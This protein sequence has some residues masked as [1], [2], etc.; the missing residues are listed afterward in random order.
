MPPLR[1]LARAAEGRQ[2]LLEMRHGD[3]D[4]V[5]T[6]MTVALENHFVTHFD[7]VLL[8]DLGYAARVGRTERPKRLE[9]ARSGFWP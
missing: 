9:C 8:P 1:A 4:S 7:V 3:S 6:L 5:M 2:L